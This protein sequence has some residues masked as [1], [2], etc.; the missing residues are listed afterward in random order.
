MEGTIFAHEYTCISSLSF[1]YLVPQ[2]TLSLLIAE[3]SAAKEGVDLMRNCG[4]MLESMSPENALANWKN[5]AES[6]QKAT[7]FMGSH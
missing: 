6:L 1:T 2:C 5:V 7:R 4:N 3:F